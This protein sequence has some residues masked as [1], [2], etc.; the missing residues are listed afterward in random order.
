MNVFLER[1]VERVVRKGNLVITGPNGGSRTFGDG[2][3][4]KVH[5]VI[6]TRHAERAITLHPSLA[7]PEMFMDEELDFVEGDVLSFLELVYR[8]IGLTW[9]D[10]TERAHSRSRDGLAVDRHPRLRRPPRAE[11]FSADGEVRVRTSG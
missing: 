11:G 8:N 7:I 2:T 5:M 4:P 1:I 6:H 9:T 3:G 10:S